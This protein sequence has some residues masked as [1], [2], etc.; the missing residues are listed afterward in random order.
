MRAAGC[1]INDI[2]D[3]HID[4]HIK[5]TASRPLASGVIPVRMH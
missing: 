4:G 5:R 1:I 3:R 2:A